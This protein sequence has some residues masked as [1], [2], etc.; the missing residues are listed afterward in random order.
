[1]ILL[2]EL[3]RYGQDQ[4][5]ET[6]EKL[7]F[8]PCGKPNADGE[9]KDPTLL[10]RL[11]GY[12]NCIGYKGFSDTVGS[13]LSSANLGGANLKDVRWNEKTN[14]SGVRGLETAINVPEAL[15]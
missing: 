4:E 5:N 3:H 7:T 14:W 6:K 12:S 1:M 13:F 10:L 9:L 15:Q 8:Y 11:I 2:L